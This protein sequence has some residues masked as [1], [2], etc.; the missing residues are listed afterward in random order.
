MTLLSHK[1]DPVACAE[2]QVN[3]VLVGTGAL[4]SCNWMDI[5]SL[6]NPAEEME[7]IDESTD[8]EIFT[9]V[10]DAFKNREN[11]EATG[12]DDDDDSGPVKPCPTTAE[13]LQAISLLNNYMDTLNNPISRKLEG[14]LASF[15]RQISM[16]QS[17]EM[18]D[19]VITNYFGRV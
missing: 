8:N 3:A 19:T 7:L 10:M 14:I 17:R 13:A 16:E 18:K 1:E 15:S 9:A 12:G 11:S 5:K 4:Q 2:Q 6:L